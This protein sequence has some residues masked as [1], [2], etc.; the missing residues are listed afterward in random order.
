MKDDSSHSVQ[1]RTLS[2][3]QH[4]GELTRQGSQG[5]QRIVKDNVV[6]TS[7]NDSVVRPLN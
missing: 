6:G 7:D 4:R 2:S 1:T 3:S 5:R